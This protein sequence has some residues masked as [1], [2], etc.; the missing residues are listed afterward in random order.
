[1]LDGYGLLKS[2]SMPFPHSAHFR[3]AAIFTFILAII[4]PA[5]VRYLYIEA[6]RR[7]RLLYGEFHG[8]F[9]FAMEAQFRLLFL[10]FHGLFQIVRAY[11]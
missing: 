2:F 9:L 10:H 7:L 1:L 5:D 6:R 4:A 8:R 11:G 3:P